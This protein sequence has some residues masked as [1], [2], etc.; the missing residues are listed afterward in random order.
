MAPGRNF[1]DFDTFLRKVR[2]SLV[3][4]FIFFYSILFFPL[5]TFFSLGIAL[6]TAQ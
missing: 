1:D 3:I 4:L 2:H 6:G 5:L